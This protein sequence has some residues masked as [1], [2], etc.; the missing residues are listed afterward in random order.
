[1]KLLSGKFFFQILLLLLILLAALFFVL[2]LV[3]PGYS[4]LGDAFESFFPWILALLALSAD[5]LREY[6]SAERR[7]FWFSYKC[8][9]D[10][11]FVLLVCL[12]V[13][14][15]RFYPQAITAAQAVFI[16]LFAMRLMAAFK[17][18][19]R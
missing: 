8:F 16:P 1:M 7:D 17:V 14:L 3:R 12:Y 6:M 9:F 2:K 18:N 15:L 5:G 13:G 19:P 11:F 4:S 10:M